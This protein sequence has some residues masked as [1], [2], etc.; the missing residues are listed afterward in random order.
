MA[1]GDRVY[2]G[3]CWVKGWG[4]EL[5]EGCGGSG[6]E[7]EGGVEGSGVEGVG[8]GLGEFGHRVD[9]VGGAVV[10]VVAVRDEA[11]D[12]RPALPLCGWD[13]QCHADWDR[14]LDQGCEIVG[15]AA[16]ALDLGEAEFPGASGGGVAD[17]EEGEVVEGFEGWE[18]VGAGD[19]Q[20][21][22][23]AGPV[24][25]GGVDLEEGGD[26]GRPSPGV[27]EGGEGLGFGGGAGDQDCV[28]GVRHGAGYRA[29]CRPGHREGCRRG[30]CCRVRCRGGRRRRR[31]PGGCA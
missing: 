15:V 22:E 6:A 28:T 13:G 2:G 4:E 20:G 30:G 17:G 18:G 26:D 29:A 12:E 16:C 11:L 10:H 5:D 24:G 25:G 14:G 7:E 9:A 1:D 8:C 27:D 31:G 19:D 3:E 23:V 21:V